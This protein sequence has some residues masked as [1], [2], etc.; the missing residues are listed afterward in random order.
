MND[1]CPYNIGD[2]VRFT[3]SK[4]TKGLYQDIERFGLKPNQVAIIRE[5]RDGVYLYFDDGKGGFPWNEFSSVHEGEA[6]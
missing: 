2:R 4:R 1:K 3:P 6:D 5:I